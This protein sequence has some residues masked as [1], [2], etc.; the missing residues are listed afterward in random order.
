M[1]V[2]SFADIMATEPSE[3]C[4]AAKMNKMIPETSVYDKPKKRTLDNPNTIWRLPTCWIFVY[5]G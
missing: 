5:E 2:M 3:E 4:R 1:K